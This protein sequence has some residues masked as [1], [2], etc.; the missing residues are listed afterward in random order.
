M[1]LITILFLFSRLLPSLS[2]DMAPQ[3]IDCNDEDVFQAVDAALKKYNARNHTGNQFVLYRVSEATKMVGTDIFYSF[4]YQIKEGNCSVQSGKTWQDCEYKDAQEAATGAC[5]ATVGKRRNMNFS[6]AT[7]TCQITPGTEGPTVRAE[8]TCLGCVHPI[9][10]D[11]PDL[12]QLLKHGIE[13]FNNNTDHSHLFALEEVKIAQRQVVAGFNFEI[14]YSIV[15]TNCSKEKFLF[16]TP[17]CK[18][19]LNSD[20]GE[21]RDKVYVNIEQKIAA[22]SQS[23]D[24]YPGEDLVQPLP[25]SCPGC[26]QDIPADSP[27]LKDALDH[28]IRKLNAENNATF[29]F[30]IDTV[31]KATSQVV[32]GIKYVIEFTAKETECSK[33]S[34]TELTANCEAKQPGQSLSCTA[35]V[36]M[37][38]WEKKVF[39]TVKCQPL[40]MVTMMRRPPGFSPFRT[41]QVQ[42]TK[43]GT[44]VSPPYTSVIEQGPIGHGHKHEH[45][46]VHSPP[47]RHG[48]GHGHQKQHDLGHGHQL[49]LDHNLKH[50]KGHGFGHGHPTGHDIAHKHKHGRDHEQRKNKDKISG[51]HTDRR[52]ESSASSS[53][54]SSTSTQTP[55]RTEGPSTLPPLVQPSVA[56]T[57]GFEDSDLIEGMVAASPSNPTEIDDDLIPDI[58]VQADRL[59]F[60]LIP[61]FPETAP[62]N[63]P[64]R[65]WKPGNRKNPT[66][67]MK[68]FSDFELSDALS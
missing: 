22:F 19:L 45:D 41:V 30:K 3:E 24:L 36:Y 59:L 37:R 42:E 29:Y 32:G 38:L 16:L 26:P 64:G 25:K 13:H 47:K 63:C 61:D 43:E 11:S 17:E 66:M 1:K 39:P 55:G 49:K 34:N 53:E 31:K 20:V 67:E 33:E 5:T 8:Y 46:Q 57:S 44:T 27:D 48:L 18:S 21:C 6:V 7:Q 23:C 51:K 58:H 28:S 54:D 65:P 15:Q 10:T 35:E 12:E 52:T 68:E 50:P 2:Q 14:T 62:H 40:E 9:P 4:K 60:K 56:V